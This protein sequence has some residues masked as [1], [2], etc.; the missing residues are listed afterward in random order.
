MQ[1]DSRLIGKI[2]ADGFADDAVNLW[3]F[4]GTAA[5]EPMFTAMAKYLYLKNGFGHCTAD[6]LS[7][8]LWLPPHTKK[9][10][11]L[12]GDMTL[13]ATQARYAGL[14]GVRN[15]YAIDGFLNKQKPVEPHYYLFA[16][17]VHPSMQGKGVGSR[18]MRE[19]LRKADDEG[20]P[21]YLENSKSKNTRFYEGHGFQVLREVKPAHGCPPLWLMWRT[22]R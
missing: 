6:G 15:A 17:A 5:M 13:A 9:K 21:V 3:A 14:T 16:I 12:V 18:L 2:I 11:G 8:A 4:N 10:F 1:S 20:M 7:D 22:P 19:P